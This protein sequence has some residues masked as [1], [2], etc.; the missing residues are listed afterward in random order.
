MS[1]T[2]YKV[3]VLS[4]ILGLFA[5]I[6]D[7]LVAYF[8]FS[9]GPF[10]DLLIFEVPPQELYVRSFL[11]L[12]FILS[13]VVVSKLLFNRKQAEMKIRG[14]E[15][16]YRS[17]VNSTDDSI[18]VLDRNYK[19]IF[20][21]RKHLDRMDLSEDMYREHTYSDFHLQEETERFTKILDKVF[22]KGDSV[23][24]EHKSM[25]DGKYFLRTVS[26][27]KDE[28]ENIRAVTV[29][30]KNINELKE[31]SE[32][33]EKLVRELQESLESIKMLQGL[34]PMC[35]WCKKIRDDEGYWDEVEQYIEKN[36]DAS[37]SHGICPAC[38]R[39]LS[40]EIYA[41]YEKKK[42]GL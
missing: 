33:Q 28:N 19:Y 18:Y 38:L 11:L 40:P 36:S 25:R 20:M 37:F 39:E 4:I 5:G 7:A 17:L 42:I 8:I 35:A 32:Q 22:A 16:R 31:M 14:G 30:S 21:N 10:W 15:E 12:I 6:I 41:D 3:I 2:G 29:V 27:V 13:G 9:K 26:P 1:K 24:D 34:L 23:Y